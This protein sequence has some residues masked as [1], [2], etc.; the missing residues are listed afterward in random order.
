M[1]IKIDYDRCTGCRKCVDACNY[2]VLDFLDDMP[3]VAAPQKCTS[4]MKCVK[5]CPVSAISIEG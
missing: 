2:S 3:V 1:E 5:L 4:C